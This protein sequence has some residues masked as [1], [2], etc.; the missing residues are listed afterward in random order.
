MAEALSRVQDW[1]RDEASGFLTYPQS[2]A[3]YSAQDYAQYIAKEEPSGFGYF[4]AALGFWKSYCDVNRYAASS[5]KPYWSLHIDNYIIGINHSLEYILKGLYENSIGRIMEFFA[6]AE[7][8]AEQRFAQDYFADYSSFMVNAPWY[9]YPFSERQQ[10]LWSSVDRDGPGQIRKWERRLLLSVELGVKSGYGWL[11]SGSSE[12]T[13]STGETT[14]GIVQ[15][16]PPDFAAEGTKVL[17]QEGD[18]SIVSFPHGPGFTNAVIGLAGDNNARFMEIA[19]NRRI[20]VTARLK[21]SVKTSA[22]DV[23]EIFRGPLLSGEEG[24]R[25]G[26][27]VPV[28]QLLTLARDLVVLD[29]SIERVY[30]Y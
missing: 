24:S 23:R 7:K 22:Q 26:L 5:E 18:V 30:D 11:F 27:A 9:R 28:D 29:G 2:Y 17:A 12:T 4:A 1:Q 6:P 10:Q 3:V 25:V 21:G 14:I 13:Q 8:T 15:N 16:M 20:L 19:G